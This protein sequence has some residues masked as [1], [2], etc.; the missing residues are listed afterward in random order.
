MGDPT[1]EEERYA[2][3]WQL[4]QF[5]ALVAEAQGVTFDT[6]YGLPSNGWHFRFLERY[7]NP[8]ECTIQHTESSRHKA[9]DPSTIC[10]FF[11]D[12]EQL[13]AT[14]SSNGI[15]S[16]RV[17]MLDQFGDFISY[18]SKNIKSVAPKGAAQVPSPF[19]FG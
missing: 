1:L 19:L 14:T 17:G 16:G 11:K 4:R 6:K 7:P 9:Q 18:F 3:T 10:A 15:P 2:A 12:L 13:V 8:S 5:A